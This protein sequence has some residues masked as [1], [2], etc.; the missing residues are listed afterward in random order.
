MASNIYAYM[1]SN[2]SAKNIYNS[3]SKIRTRATVAFKW[4]QI[5]TSF[6]I[7][8]C[9]TMVNVQKILNSLF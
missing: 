3:L 9:T 1:Y 6:L 5:L 7:V 2:N 8:A 4:F